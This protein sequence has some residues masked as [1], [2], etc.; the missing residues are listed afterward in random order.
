MTHELK[1]WPQYYS[2]VYNGTKNFEI[3]EN[4]RCFQFGDTVILREWNPDPVSSTD[5][6]IPQGY[7]NSE[8]LTFMVG[9]V[10]VLDSRKVVFSLLPLPKTKAVKS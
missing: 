7:T 4:D 10:H 9:Y 8:P 1:I 5:S 2:R 3:R 6:S